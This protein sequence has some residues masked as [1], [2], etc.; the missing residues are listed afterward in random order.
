MA[1][2]I[3]GNPLANWTCTIEGITMSAC[4]TCAKY[5]TNPKKIIQEP[6]KKKQAPAPTAAPEKTTIQVIIPNYAQ[7]IKNA[8]EKRGLK[9]ADFAKLIAEKESVIHGLE[10]GR[11]RPNIDLARKLERSLHITL[12]Q[13]IEDSGNTTQHKSPDDTLTL[14]DL[15]R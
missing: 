3:C 7:L 4:D 2:N 6:P 5:G 1:C 9:Q 14:G 8:R 10:S 11:I 13:Q 12:V 15:L